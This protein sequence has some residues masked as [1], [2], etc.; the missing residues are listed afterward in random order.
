MCCCTTLKMNC[1][2]CQAPAKKFGKD[3][4]GHQRYR[5]LSCKKTFIESY[6][7]PLCDMR[8]PLEKALTVIQHLVE[9]CSIRS[10]VRITGVEKRTILSLL[11]L[12]G[13]RCEKLMM[14]RIRGLH[15]KKVQCDELWGF[16][17]MKEKTKAKNGKQGNQIGDAWCYTAI[18]RHSKLILTWHLGRR[19]SWDTV[20]FTEN[21]RHATSGKFQ[22]SS[23]GFQPYKDAAVYSLGA[24]GVD[25]AQVV[26][27]YAASPE[28]ETRYS[29]T[30]CIGCNKETVFGFPGLKQAST[31]H[32]ERQNLS[33]RMGMRRMTR[34]TNAFS[35]KWQNLKAAYALHFAYYNFCRVHQTLRITPAMES[36]IT[37]HV[38]TLDELMV[39][40]AFLSPKKA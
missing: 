38:W 29:P 25:F 22:I 15:V 17:G 34:L 40:R 32:V 21:L 4:D 9:G 36:K 37:H 2:A 1:Q 23:D 24:Q 28:G 12:V 10:T 7:R 19:T 35:T 3:R 18:E 31:S 30:Q 14:N 39:S 5:C 13:E 20:R 27:L 8:L 6:K 33:V 26:K 16:I 11:V